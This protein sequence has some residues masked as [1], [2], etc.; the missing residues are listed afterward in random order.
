[1]PLLQCAEPTEVLILARLR[2]PAHLAH[3]Q[4]RGA[5]LSHWL[6]RLADKIRSGSGRGA[7]PVNGEPD[8]G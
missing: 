8:L 3:D 2:G 5:L 1:M 4:N 6:R 7:S